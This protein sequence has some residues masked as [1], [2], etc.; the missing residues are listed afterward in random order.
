VRV[1]FDV[2]GGNEAELLTEAHRILDS[3][4]EGKRWNLDITAHAEVID[5]DDTVRSWRGE[6][7]A[8]HEDPE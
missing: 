8:F 5:H 1:C 2:H 4:S 3:F 7:E 6:V